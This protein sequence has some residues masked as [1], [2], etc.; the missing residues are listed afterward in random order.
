MY[1]YGVLVLIVPFPSDVAASVGIPF[2]TIYAQ[3]FADEAALSCDQNDVTASNETSVED[4][5]VIPTDGA[6]EPQVGL[7]STVA[8]FNTPALRALAKLLSPI[9]PHTMTEAYDTLPY[10]TCED[11]YL[12]DMPEVVR[13]NDEHEVLDL[14]NLFFELKEKVYKELENARNEKIIGSGLEAEVR[15]N[16]DNKYKVILSKI[17]RIHVVLQSIYIWSFT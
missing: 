3:P 9:L 12:E 13:Y 5:L 8:S 7:S 17:L 2:A 15:I 16:L 14:F 4:V 10:K 6:Q 11:V 1:V